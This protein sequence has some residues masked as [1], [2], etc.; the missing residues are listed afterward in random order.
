MGNTLIE[1]PQRLGIAAQQMVGE[2]GQAGTGGPAVMMQDETGDGLVAGL[3]SFGGI[4]SY[5]SSRW[6][7]GCMVL[8]SLSRRRVLRFALL[9]MNYNRLLSSTEHK[10][11][12]LLADIS[13]SPGSTAWLC[14]SYLSY[15]LLAK[16][17]RYCRLCVVR[18]HPTIPYTAGANQTLSA[19][20]SM[21]DLEGLFTE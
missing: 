11:T 17:T 9:L 10:S 2:A 7:F 3:R 14:A 4:F 20:T 13:I 21:L 16:Y 6:A 18:P 19:L 5:A 15:F 8:V 12:L 1:L